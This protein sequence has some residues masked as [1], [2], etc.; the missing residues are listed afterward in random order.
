MNKLDL[1]AIIVCGQS[2]GLMRQQVQEKLREMEEE[3][4]KSKM[5]DL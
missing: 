3:D 1:K 5:Q 2:D 4:E